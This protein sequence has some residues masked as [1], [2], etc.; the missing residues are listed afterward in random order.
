MPQFLFS[1]CIQNSVTVYVRFYQQ[2]RSPVVLICQH[3]RNTSP[4]SSRQQMVC[5]CKIVNV[6]IFKNY[7]DLQIIRIYHEVLERI[8]NSVPRVTV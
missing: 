1:G 6:C 3:L 2:N 4:T 8:D 7:S 5:P